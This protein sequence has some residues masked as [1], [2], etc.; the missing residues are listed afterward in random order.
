[1]RGRREATMSDREP[2]HAGRARWGADLAV[3]LGAAVVWAVVDCVRFGDVASHTAAF[4]IALAGA[5][6]TLAPLTVL[7]RRARGPRSFLTIG[8]IAALLSAGPLTVLGALLESRTHHRALGAVTFAI[9]ATGI[10]LAT[11]VVTRR[12]LLHPRSTAQ[13]KVERAALASVTFASMC[14][15]LGSLAVAFGAGTKA[16]ARD[17]TVD[18]VVGVVLLGWAVL[19]PRPR[20]PP[21]AAWAAGGLWLAA[22]VA[23]WATVNGEPRV[24]K[25]F[26]ERAPMTLGIMGVLQ[27]N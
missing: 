15:F 13:G 3:G 24:R 10:A 11:L 22:T 16:S 26:D 12:L 21:W 9:L 20:V 27:E 4:V 17:A 14:I 5:A 8:V 7:G 25:I 1:M 2:A 19:L 6:S 23:G 18:G